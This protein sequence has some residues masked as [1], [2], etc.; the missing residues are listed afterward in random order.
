MLSVGEGAG[1][2]AYGGVAG[3]IEIGASGMLLARQ[4]YSSAAGNLRYEQSGG[5]V[6]LR[7]ALRD[8]KAVDY[9]STRNPERDYEPGTGGNI[10]A[11]AATFSLAQPGDAFIFRGG[12]IRI[13][14]HAESSKSENPLVQI[15]CPSTN[16]TVEG[17]K[18]SFDKRFAR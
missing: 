17:G 1:P 12:E 16:Y 8:T 15:L 9:Q 4:I 6:L 18:L 7:G 10:Y 5:L 2:A 11:D 13:L 3:S 14:A